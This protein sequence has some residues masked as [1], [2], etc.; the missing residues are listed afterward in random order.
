M[1]RALR[2]CWK[3]RKHVH[4]NTCEVEFPISS[5]VNDTFLV[6]DHPYCLESLANLPWES[7]GFCNLD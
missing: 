3:C 6:K 2:L 5:V 7:G 1:A 4:S